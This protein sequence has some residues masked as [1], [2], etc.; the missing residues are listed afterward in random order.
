LLRTGIF[1]TGIR[2]PL[3]DR[4]VCLEVRRTIESTGMSRSYFLLFFGG[5]AGVMSITEASSLSALRFSNSATS[6]SSSEMST[7]LV[8]VVCAEASG[9]TNISRASTFFCAFAKLLDI[10]DAFTVAFEIGLV[11]CPCLDLIGDESLRQIALLAYTRSGDVEALP[12][13]GSQDFEQSKQRVSTTEVGDARLESISVLAPISGF[14]VSLGLSLLLL[15]RWWLLHAHVDLPTID[16]V[17]D[18]LTQTVKQDLVSGDGLDTSVFVDGDVDVLDGTVVSMSS[19]SSCS[20]GASFMGT[21]SNSWSS[22]SEEEEASSS[23]LSSLSP[24]PTL[25]KKFLASSAVALVFRVSIAS[26]TLLL[27][28]VGLVSLEELLARAS[29]TSVDTFATRQTRPQN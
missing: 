20:L 16:L 21:S 27:G 14:A 3:L 4:H 29:M 12:P 25:A 10:L 23:S 18:A 9:L 11:L 24:L 17:F 15:L 2:N 6:L 26:K 28:L 13:V 1:S 5:G 8:D 7:G 22:S 19:P